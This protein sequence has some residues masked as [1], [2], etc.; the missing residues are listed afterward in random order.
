MAKSR[1]TAKSFADLASLRA[2][3]ADE[4]T[5]VSLKRATL[6]VKRQGADLK[7]HPS[8]RDYKVE[9][10]WLANEESGAR[11]RPASQ[12]A[13]DTSALNRP[14][15][16]KL[17][18]PALALRGDLVS[19]RSA[20]QRTSQCVDTCTGN[21]LV[22]FADEQHAATEVELL[23]ST[24]SLSTRQACCDQCGHF[25]LFDVQGLPLV[26]KARPEERRPPTVRKTL[27]V[28]DREE[29]PS[30]VSSDGFPKKCYRDANEARSVIDGLRIRLRHYE[31]PEGR[32]FHLTSKIS[33]SRAAGPA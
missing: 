10:V 23:W 7:P 19:R 26:G 4:P 12:K 30:C 31:C 14:A 22:S 8:K 5:P 3:L 2:H 27:R 9:D 6:H 16:S 15:S 29:C 20:Q 24:I 32:G 1:G 17:T 25:H 21:L 13:T 11:K 33:R 18:K 28:G